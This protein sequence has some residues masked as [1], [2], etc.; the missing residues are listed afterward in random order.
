MADNDWV[1]GQSVTNGMRLFD[2]NSGGSEVTSGTATIRYAMNAAGTTKWLQDDLATVSTTF[3]TIAVAHTANEG[4]VHK[5]TVPESMRG[6]SG[7]FT[8]TDPAT[9]LDVYSETFETAGLPDT[10]EELAIRIV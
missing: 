6:L 3:N 8:V 4:F 9:G 5:F 1:V 10:Q 7:T 2:P